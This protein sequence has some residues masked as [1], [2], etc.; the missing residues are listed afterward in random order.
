MI[1]FK[2]NLTGITCC[3]NISSSQA[4]S[5]TDLYHQLRRRGGASTEN[6]REL[7][8][9]PRILRKLKM[10]GYEVLDYALKLRAFL[11]CKSRCKI[12]L[13]WFN[14]TKKEILLCQRPVVETFAGG[15][16]LL[17]RWGRC[18]EARVAALPPAFFTSVRQPSSRSLSS[19]QG[20]VPRR[21]C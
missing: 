16:E 2:L 17:R 20:P 10:R 19:A 3:D 13:D 18:L 1:V 6:P 9:V 21:C 14:R 5:I 8:D 7:L 12:A 11:R 4:R 15:A